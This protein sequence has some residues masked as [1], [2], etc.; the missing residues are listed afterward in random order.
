MKP[1]ITADDPWASRWLSTNS[2]S[3][4]PYHVTKFTP[5]QEVVYQANPNY[6]QGPAKLERVIFREMPT[7]ANRLA[8]LQAGSVDVA[9]WLLPRE[10]ATLEKIPAVK[11]WKVFGN[12]IH[13]VEMNNTVPPFDQPEGAPGAELPGPARP[14][15]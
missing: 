13:R 1:H 2:A 11:V 6:W 15:S 3:F 8:S 14:R 12:Y 9:E 7:S 5:G 4:A 10:F